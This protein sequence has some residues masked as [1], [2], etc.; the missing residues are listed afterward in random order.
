MIKDLNPQ[1]FGFLLEILSSVTTP[2]E[3][4]PSPQKTLLKLHPYLAGNQDFKNHLKLFNKI[5]L[6]TLQASDDK[7]EPNKACKDTHPDIGVLPADAVV[8]DVLFEAYNHTS[9]PSRTLSLSNYFHALEK[10]INNPPEFKTEFSTS[11]HKPTIADKDTSTWSDMSEADKNAVMTPDDYTQRPGEDEETFEAR[12]DVKIN[13]L[14]QDIAR[15]IEG[16]SF[17]VKK[18]DAEGHIT[19]QELI[20]DLSLEE[21]ARHEK[22]IKELEELFETIESYTK[23]EQ[24]QILSCMRQQFVTNAGREIPFDLPGAGVVN[25]HVTKPLH[26][27]ITIAFGANV[28]AIFSKT[29]SLVELDANKEGDLLKTQDLVTCQTEAIFTPG[30]QTFKTKRYK[31]SLLGDRFDSDHIRLS[32]M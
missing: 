15:D 21:E 26:K 14:K 28:I 16:L 10:F 18:I 3:L 8:E 27:G 25:G 20:P 30:R 7:E 32:L 29:R 6:E 23:A 24:V 1:N 22:L 2:Q 19:T 5:S 9:E 31:T 17:T 13:E 4:E 12:C 11:A